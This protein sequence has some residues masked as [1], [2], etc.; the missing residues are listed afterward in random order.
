M[1]VPSDLASLAFI[2]YT[3]KSKV[4]FP[5]PGA[6]M[7]C[8]QI[9]HP[10]IVHFIHRVLFAAATRTITHAV[11]WSSFFIRKFVVLSVGTKRRCREL[12]KKKRNRMKHSHL[13]G[14]CVWAVSVSHP[15]LEER[16]TVTSTKG[17]VCVGQVFHSDT[18]HRRGSLTSWDLVT[19]I[20]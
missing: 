3:L 8:S 16:S 7:G 19:K 5:A 1:Y 15:T 20:V 10:L 6:M 12:L 13:A 14:E 17:S 9:S 2:K 18:E 4:F 11:G